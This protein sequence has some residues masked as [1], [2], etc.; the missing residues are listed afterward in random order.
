[1]VISQPF[2]TTKNTGSV[3]RYTEG[4]F[5]SEKDIGSEPSVEASSVNFGTYSK[6]NWGVYQEDLSVH[7]TSLTPCCTSCS[8]GSTPLGLPASIWVF[9]ALPVQLFAVSLSACAVHYLSLHESRTYVT[10]VQIVWESGDGVRR[11][12]ATI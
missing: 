4:S 1:M 3:L 10:A 2:G 11:K 5:R 12:E 7:R 9:T 6:T 8:P